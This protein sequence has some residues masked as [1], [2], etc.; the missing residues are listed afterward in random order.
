MFYRGKHDKNNSISFQVRKSGLL[1]ISL[2]MLIMVGI[3]GTVAYLLDY[4][5][6]LVNIFNPSR[7]EITVNEDFAENTKE[8][9]TIQNTGNTP[10]WIRAKVL[11]YWEDAEG[12]IISEVP[13]DYKYEPNSFTQDVNWVQFDGYYYWTAIVPVGGSTKNLINSITADTPSDPQYFLRV[14]ILADAV[15][16]APQEAIQQAWGVTISDGNV[17][18]AAEQGGA[19]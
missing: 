18:A 11:I 12:N 1:L 14:Q 13:G 10:V 7:V 6:A 8:N 17:S 2:V 15:Q 4:T 9:V 19:G 5:D 16:S 3:G